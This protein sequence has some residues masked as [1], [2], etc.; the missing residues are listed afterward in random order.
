MTRSRPAAD[1][2][3]AVD[4]GSNSF[5][6]IIARAYGG[7]LRTLDRRREM[8]QLG[9][10][11]NRKNQLS[12][13]AE[14]RALRCLRRFGQRLRGMP[15]DAVRA[16]GTNTL[17][18]A[19]NA[20]GFL[21]A[22]ERALGHPIEVIAGHEE[23][24][25]IYLG[26]AHSLPPGR[27]PRLVVD[28]GGGSTEII[29]G[30]GF[31]VAHL[32]SVQAGCVAC[33]LRYFPDGVITAQRFNQAELALRQEL[34]PVAGRLRA[35]PWEQCVGAS[36]TINAIQEIVHK[37][38]WSEGAVTPTALAR[39]R[40]RM[41]AAGHVDKLDFPGLKRARAAVLPGGVAILAAL[42]QALSIKRMQYASGA[43][44]EGLLYDML[45]RV[46]HEDVR[47]RTIE[48][49]TERYAIDGA[50]ARRVSASALRLLRQAG[51]GWG[52]H[53]QPWRNLLQWAA[54]LHEI[55]LSVSYSQ[56]R[57]HGAYLIEHADLPGFSHREQQYLAALVLSQRGKPG[58]A[59]MRVFPRAARG[60][61]MKLCVLLRLAVLLCR[62][63]RAP[64]APRVTVRGD[65]I[66]LTFPRGWLNKHPLTRADL[67][68]EAE[69]LKALRV[70]LKFN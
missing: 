30:R 12:R 28:I 34:Q 18:L 43:L 62:N 56:Y 38:G 24:R 54:R 19:Q 53:A 17:R 44:R 21:R 7:G 15:P 4:L 1:V 10:G 32:A 23:A 63:R 69:H 25:L 26:V 2:L 39:L 40:K 41:I 27:K 70:R 3:A 61:L 49:L 59:A 55:G 48:E 66:K 65:A 13:D 50:Q 51:A 45:G 37:S 60:A 16:V 57:K 68:D 22:A 36:G 11:L 42:F 46:R 9:A 67:N 6:M 5:H 31:K 58:L 8:V 29:V 47:A 33:S 64:A 14:R 35:L 52:L 20:G